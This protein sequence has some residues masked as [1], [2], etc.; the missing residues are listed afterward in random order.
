MF[1][2]PHSETLPLGMKIGY[3]RVST[4]DQSLDMQLDALKAAGCERI[5]Q[6]KVSGKNKDRPELSNCLKALRS[7]DTLVVWKLDRL[8]RNVADLIHLVNLLPERGVGFESLTEKIDTSSAVGQ[9]VF[10]FFAIM[11]DFE[12]AINK[13][14]TMAGLA[15]AK[16]RGVVGGRPRKMS[17]ADVE[18]ARALA[19]KGVPLKNIRKMFGVSKATLFIRL[20]EQ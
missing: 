13:E 10:H 15:A 19:A 1:Q 7:G 3:A 20:N 14:R 2:K 18:E 5:Y 17:P 16:K 6:E 8:G 4:Q 11:A 12:R 9:L